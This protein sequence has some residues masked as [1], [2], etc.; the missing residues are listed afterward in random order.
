MSQIEGKP[1]GNGICSPHLY[2]RVRACVCMC[3]CLQPRKEKKKKK[4]EKYYAFFKIG[5]V[6]RVISRLPNYLLISCTPDNIYR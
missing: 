2:I 4:K 6:P 3:V 5:T 1:L